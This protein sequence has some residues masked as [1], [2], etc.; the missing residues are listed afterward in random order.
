MKLI[1]DGDKQRTVN[2][3]PSPRQADRVERDSDSNGTQVDV[4]TTP[5]HPALA[6]LGVGRD[7]RRLQK[8][9][10]LLTEECGKRG[11][12]YRD[13]SDLESFGGTPDEFRDSTRRTA[14]NVQRMTNVLFNAPSAS[15]RPT[16]P[17]DVELLDQLEKKPGVTFE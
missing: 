16:V 6:A 1:S 15:A 4:I 7:L 9:R 5:E 10:T 13:F 14:T 17:T 12:V 8:R 2:A 11:F 3:S